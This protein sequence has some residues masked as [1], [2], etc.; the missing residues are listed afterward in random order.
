MALFVP[1]LQQRI[2]DVTLNGSTAGLVCWTAATCSWILQHDFQLLKADTISFYFFFC[3]HI[4]F[5]QT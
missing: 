1:V 4:F 3:K 5:L 2:P